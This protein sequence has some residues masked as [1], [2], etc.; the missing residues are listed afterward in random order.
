MELVLTFDTGFKSHCHTNFY[1][2]CARFPTQKK[3]IKFIL[4]ELM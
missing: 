4:S 1:K 2:S 3:I